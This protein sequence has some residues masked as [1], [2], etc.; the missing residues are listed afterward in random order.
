MRDIHASRVDD[1]AS[2]QLRELQRMLVLNI[3]AEI[4]T[5]DNFGDVTEWLDERLTKI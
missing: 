1:D 5:V 3:K 4:Q 2:E